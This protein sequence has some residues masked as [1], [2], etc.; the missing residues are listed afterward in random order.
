MT[1]SRTPSII[2]ASFFQNFHNHVLIWAQAW[3]TSTL[4]GGGRGLENLDTY[5]YFRWNGDSAR[6]KIPIFGG[7]PSWKAHNI[8]PGVCPK[9]QFIR[10]YIKIY[11]L[12]TVST[13]PRYR[14]RVNSASPF[15]KVISIHISQSTKERITDTKEKLIHHCLLYILYME[16]TREKQPSFRLTQHT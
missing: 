2:V 3:R 1:S 15:I 10:C 13:P 9:Y 5:C 11:T 12:S 7:H 6:L 14:R 8:F 16:N 4:L